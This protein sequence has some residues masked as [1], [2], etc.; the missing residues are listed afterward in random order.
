MIKQFIVQKTWMN[1]EHQFAVATF[2]NFT[3]WHCEFGN[4]VNTV[5]NAVEA[6]TQEETVASSF[7]DFNS[8]LDTIDGIM[9]DPKNPKY[10]LR[11]ILCYLRSN[12]IPTVDKKRLKKYYKNGYFVVDCIYLH[13]PVADDNK[14]QQAY[15]VLSDLDGIDETSREDNHLVACTNL[16]PNPTMGDKTDSAIGEPLDLVRLS[17]DERIYVKMRGDRELKGRLHAYDQHMNLVLSD[18]EETITHVEINEQTFE[19]L[20]RVWISAQ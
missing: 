5:V 1:S 3:L 6:I 20:V 16:K 4:D 18:V 11:I 2:T 15:D 7:W 19:E 10:V 12:A 14:V 9:P 13:D 17:L 8:L